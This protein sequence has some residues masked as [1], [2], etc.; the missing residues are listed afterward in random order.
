MAFKRLFLI[1]YIVFICLCFVYKLPAKR[2]WRSGWATASWLENFAT[3]PPSGDPDEH[4][5][6][7]SFSRRDL[8]AGNHCLDQDTRTVRRRLDD[9]SLKIIVTSILKLRENADTVA[10]NERSAVVGWNGGIHIKET[11]CFCHIRGKYP[12]QVWLYQVWS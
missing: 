1:Q 4:P 9:D 8:K 11:H 2:P 7:D 6:L 3:R 12:E 10:G 5:R